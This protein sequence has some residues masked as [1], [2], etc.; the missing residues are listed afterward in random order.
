MAAVTPLCIQTLIPDSHSKVGLHIHIYIHMSYKKSFS[1][2]SLVA[3][4]IFFYLFECINL[5][6]Y[7]AVRLLVLLNKG[8]TYLLT[9]I[10]ISL[11]G[12]VNQV[13]PLT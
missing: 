2:N 1:F 4:I 5:A 13:S 12:I 10:Q 8:Y 9:Y 11:P 7:S 3:Y 6:M